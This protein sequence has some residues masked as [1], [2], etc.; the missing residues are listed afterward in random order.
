MAGM[1]A[2]ESPASEPDSELL[3]L[4][5]ISDSEPDEA[6]PSTSDLDGWEVVDVGEENVIDSPEQ[7]FHS[8]RG[9]NAGPRGCWAVNAKGY[10]CGAAKLKER[11]YCAAHSGMGVAA[12]P[13]R[14]APL[15]IEASKEARA[16]RAQMRLQLGITR[17]GGPRSVLKARAF[18]EAERLA[19]TAINGAFD[20][21]RLALAII[22][23]ADPAPQAEISVS[24]PLSVEDV[25]GM[26]MS[27]LFAVAE[28]LGIETPPLPESSGST[29]P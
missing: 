1:E 10:P 23:E 22:K 7:P 19:A 29:T 25:N 17:K 5:V 16:V 4:D 13:A 20:D 15:G 2:A 11:D 28:R 3:P 14:Y 12:D 6:D 26:S 24:A 27:Q 8:T 18:A 21:P 9:D